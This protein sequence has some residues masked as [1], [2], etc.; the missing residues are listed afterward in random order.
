M[1]QLHH[2]MHKLFNDINI[3]AQTEH[4]ANLVD[5]AQITALEESIK[6]LVTDARQPKKAEGLGLHKPVTEVI[7]DIDVKHRVDKLYAGVFNSINDKLEKDALAVAKSKS[8]SQAA[9]A[10]SAKQTPGE[11]LAFFFTR[12]SFFS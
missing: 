12:V 4:V 3:E 6:K 1:H 9:E 5:A 2:A 8:D 7:A 11:V 10:A